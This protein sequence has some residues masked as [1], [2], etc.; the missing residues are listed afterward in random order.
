[1]AATGAMEAIY[2]L[3]AA[4]A[5]MLSVVLAAV[6]VTLGTLVLT[7]DASVAPVLSGSMR[8]AFKEGD[9]VVVRPID[10][11]ALEV[12]RVAV[13]AP[14]ADPGRAVAHRIL[15]VE[16]RDDGA[17]VRTRGD[18]NAHPDPGPVII[19][20]QRTQVVVGHVPLLG[21]LV[22]AADA[23]GARVTLA[24]VVVGS[25]LLVLVRSARARPSG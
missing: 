18:A 1:M 21:H 20:E 9:L 12:G 6:A 23:V 17:H 11:A 14:S 8:P 4:F 24:I 15:S 10:T 3:L 7:L 13:L 2:V 22:L 5:R 19:T 16:H 25:L